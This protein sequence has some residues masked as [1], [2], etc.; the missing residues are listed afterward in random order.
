MTST[1]GCVITLAAL[2]SVRDQRSTRTG[3]KLKLLKF[4]KA[5]RE[6]ARF[7]LASMLWLHALFLIRPPSEE[8]D[9]LARRL[10]FTT[11]EITLLVIISMLSLLAR[12]G[13]W[14]S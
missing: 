14:V 3:G 12:P 4:L 6:T 11:P 9:R 2:V 1:L 5:L 8:V 10:S 7:I 13:F